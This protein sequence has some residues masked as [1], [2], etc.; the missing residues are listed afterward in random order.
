MPLFDRI[1]RFQE[2]SKEANNSNAEKIRIAVLDSGIDERDQKIRA[3]IFSKRIKK[4]QSKSFVGS[5]DED[6]QDTHGHGTHVTKLLLDTAQAAEI[7]V[8]KVFTE[9]N[10][11]DEFMSGIAKVKFG[12]CSASASLQ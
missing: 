6:L 5:S 11:K 1:A 10:I 7:Y 9:R 4:I 3:A 2:K 8:G 12:S